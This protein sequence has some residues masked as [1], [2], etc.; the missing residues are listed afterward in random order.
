MREDDST[1]QVIVI[2]EFDASGLMRR[3]QASINDVPI[4]AADRKFHWPAGL[5]LADHAGLTE[6]G[7]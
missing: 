3:R 4:L 7:L 6:F 5:R 2:D 1:G